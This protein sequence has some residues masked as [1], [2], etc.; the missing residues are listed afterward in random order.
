MTTT[1]KV[2]L[3]TLVCAVPA[4]ILG[5]IIWP[6]SPDLPTPTSMQLPFFIILS[7]IEAVVFGLGV[8]FIVL[9]WNRAGGERL[10]F[11]AIAWF[12]ISWWP[13]DNMHKH[14][15]EDLGGLLVIEYLFHV[16]LIV[17]GVII[18]MSFWKRLR[19]AA[20]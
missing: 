1:V 14:N 3:I 5:N 10:V 7:V 9:G 8:A 19:G 2:A 6:I 15:G 11:L 17:A 4:L 16:T 20:T 18:A 13:H 12:L